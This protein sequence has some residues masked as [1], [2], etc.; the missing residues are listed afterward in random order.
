MKKI[1]CTLFAFIMAASVLAGCRDG[2]SSET[3][4]PTSGTKPTT[5]Q[6]KPTTSQTQP[7]TS[8]TM[9][10]TRPTTPSGTDGSG[11][12]TIPGGTAT[13]RFGRNGMTGNGGMDQILPMD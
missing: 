9:P 6:T 1:I 8:A 2:S 4:R 13:R 10:T 3:S 7:S 5:S 11:E 12:T